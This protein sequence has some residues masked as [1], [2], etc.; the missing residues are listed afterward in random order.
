MKKSGPHVDLYG[1]CMQKNIIPWRTYETRK[2]LNNPHHPPWKTGIP[3]KCCM[4]KCYHYR[5]NFP[6]NPHLLPRWN[7]KKVWRSLTRWC[8]NFMS[9]LTEPEENHLNQPNLRDFWY[10]VHFPGCMVYLPIHE[11]MEGMGLVLEGRRKKNMD[12]FFGKNMTRIY[13][14]I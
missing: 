3:C 6:N 7:Y 9:I 5:W 8:R 4:V 1:K 14:T 10:Y 12:P 13:Y 11:C 2:C